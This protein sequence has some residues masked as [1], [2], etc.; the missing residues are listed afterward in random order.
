[1]IITTL[2]YKQSLPNNRA[3]AQP[4]SPHRASGAPQILRLRK[5]PYTT[6][7]VFPALYPTSRPLSYPARAGIPNYEEGANTPSRTRPETPASPTR[8][9]TTVT[10]T[11]HTRFSVNLSKCRTLPDSANLPPGLYCSADKACR[12]DPLLSELSA[13]AHSHIFLHDL[14]ISQSYTS[15]SHN[16]SLNNDN[17]RNYI[18]PGIYL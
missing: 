5:T 16:N 18:N 2:Q 12:R 14:L 8:V 6:L 3:S 15:E 17:T 4:R 1:M 7:L 9:S 11:L 10:G 13:T